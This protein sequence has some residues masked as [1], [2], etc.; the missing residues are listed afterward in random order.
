M[1][2]SDTQQVRV[3]FGFEFVRFSAVLY[4]KRRQVESLVE[5]IVKWFDNVVVSVSIIHTP[6]R[7]YLSP[8]PVLPS[9][10][11]AGGFFDFLLA[12]S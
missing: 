1:E 2:P 9:P 11:Y 8:S 7:K 5:V 4:Y 10:L 6:P 3:I 12:R